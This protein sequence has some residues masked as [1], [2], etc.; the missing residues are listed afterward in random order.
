MQ[1]KAYP[2][3]KPDF[4]TRKTKNVGMFLFQNGGYHIPKP[5]PRK[6]RKNSGKIQFDR[7]KQTLGSIISNCICGSE[8]CSTT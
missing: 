8:D 7:E 6:F 5:S 2:I 1:K 4:R 3:G